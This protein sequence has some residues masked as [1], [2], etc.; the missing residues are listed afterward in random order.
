MFRFRKPGIV[1]LSLLCMVL[2]V[3]G[4]FSAGA[5]PDKPSAGSAAD[6]VLSRVHQDG[7]FVFEE[8][9]WLTTR[10]G[11]VK[12]KKLDDAAPDKDN[13]QAKGSLLVDTSI[14]QLVTYTFQDDKLVSGEYVFL[15]LDK[16][17]F[18][19]LAGELK[20]ALAKST[21][22]TPMSNNLN[23][24]DQA[25]ESATAGKSVAWEGKNGSHLKINLLMTKL[26]DGK[27][28]YMLQIQSGSPLPERKSLKP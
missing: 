17:L 13:I 24:L 25:D 1:A 27:P 23:V 20:E 26:Q 21:L 2:V 28:G 19:E 22:G 12:Q 16:G 3:S 7:S 4:C 11:V 8:L 10:E 18:T 15:M 5:S 14:E 6:Q 9:P